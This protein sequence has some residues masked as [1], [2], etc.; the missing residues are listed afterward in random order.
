MLLVQASVFRELA[1]L[2]LSLTFFANERVA[3]IAVTRD[4]NIGGE[5]AG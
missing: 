2:L 3:S 4:K 5:D 1:P